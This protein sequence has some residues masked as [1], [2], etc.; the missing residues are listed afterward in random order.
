MIRPIAALLLAGCLA[1]P[2]WAQAPAP[3]ASP[4]QTP[5][6]PAQAPAGQIPA[7]AAQPAGQTSASESTQFPLDRFKEFSAIQTSGLLPGSDFDGYVYRSGDL[8][9]MQAVQAGKTQYFV[10]DLVRGTSYGLSIAGCAKLP[11]LY[12]RTYPWFM[13][14]P[15]YTY[16]RVAVGE[17]TVDGHHCRVED[18]T[19][20]SPKQANPAHF[21]LYEADDLQ[22]F[23]IKI[24]NQQEKVRRWIIHY[25]NVVL[26]PQDPTLFVVPKSCQSLSGLVPVHPSGP[27]TKPKKAPGDKPK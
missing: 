11:Y 24:V 3:L 7:A 22:G 21:R 12:S 15:G 20:R 1:L 6:V 8:M 27:G 18:I 10:D 4:A 19:V 13:S 9:R 2:V 5:A 23:P 16:E 26:G 17:E 25:K 14:G